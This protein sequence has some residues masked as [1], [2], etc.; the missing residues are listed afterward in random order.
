MGEVQQRIS[1]VA[2]GPQP[3]HLY[4]QLGLEAWDRGEAGRTMVRLR[5]R[6]TEKRM[7]SFWNRGYLW[8]YEWRKGVTSEGYCWAGSGKILGF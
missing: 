8:G 7:I 1:R 5:F 2:S 6:D 3:C 4:Q